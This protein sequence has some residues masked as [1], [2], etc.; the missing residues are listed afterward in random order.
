MLI[1][2]AYAQFGALPREVY[3]YSGRYSRSESF[4]RYGRSVPGGMTIVRMERRAARAIQPV[5]APDDARKVC[6][7]W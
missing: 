4:S 5:P 7:M 6:G 2:P 1:T 3:P